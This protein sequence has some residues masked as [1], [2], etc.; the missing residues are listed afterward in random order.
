MP[1]PEKRCKITFAK[2]HLHARIEV[3][4]G[5]NLMETIVAAGLPVASSC[6]GEGVCAKCRLNIVEG[7]EN[8]SRPDDL[9][10]FLAERYELK[11]HQRISCQCVVHGDIKVDATYW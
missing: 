7:Q 5:A 9:E 11:S 2:E 6:S 4:E 3:A 1:P 10:E 8:L